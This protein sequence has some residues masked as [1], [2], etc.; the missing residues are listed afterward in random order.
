M[1]YVFKFLLVISLLWPS[2]A[3]GMTYVGGS[4]VD[5]MAYVYNGTSWVEATKWHYTGSAWQEIEAG[6]PPE[7]QTLTINPVPSNGSIVEPG[8]GTNINCG[9]SGSNCEQ[10][11]PFNTNVTLTAIADSGYQLDSW[12]G[13]DVDNGDGTANVIMD[14]AKTVTASFVEESGDECDG[15][16]VCQNFEGTGYD[17]GETWTEEY[18]D[19]GSGVTINPDY[20]TTVLRGSES[21]YIGSD[22][23]RK[24]WI[25]HEFATDLNEIYIH[26][27]LQ[28]D[29]VNFDLSIMDIKDSSG[30]IVLSLHSS[31]TRALILAQGTVEGYSGVTLDAGT[32]Y[33]IWVT[34][35]TSLN[36][37]LYISADKNRPTTSDVTITG[38]DP[39][40]VHDISMIRGNSH[41]SIMDQVLVKDTDFN[42]VP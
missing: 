10:V 15:F 2:L 23:Y 16:L 9:T 1:I 8:D 40:A 29:D 3:L 18:E 22:N 30:N 11:Y 25:I 4:W 38:D 36:T 13:V 27:M 32:V 42:T 37:S 41:F 35:D 39:A 26:F 21:L 33:H 31:S 34:M 6:T 14:S 7:D 12:T 20:T 17:N 28:I 5:D 19:G 24:G